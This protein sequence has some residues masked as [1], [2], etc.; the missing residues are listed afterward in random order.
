MTSSYDPIETALLARLLVGGRKPP[1]ELEVIKSLRPIVGTAE[2]RVRAALTRLEAD[3]LRTSEMKL[4]T[5]GRERARE[6]LGTTKLPTRWPGMKALLV[7]LAL[8]KTQKRNSRRLTPANVRAAALARKLDLPVA[9]SPA[10]VL[11]A[12]AARVLGMTGQRL[13]IVNVRAHVLSQ[14]L[15]ISSLRNPSHIGALAS[16]KLLGVARSDADSVRDAVLRDW[17]SAP[18]TETTAAAEEDELDRFASTVKEIARDM[19]DDGRFGRFKVFIAP[20]W[21]RARSAPLFAR[22]S[23][24][25]FKGK[26]VAAHRAGLLRLTRADLTP[27][28]RREL[29]A[30]SEVPYLNAAFHFVD[31]E[32]TLS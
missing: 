7:E 10:D 21:T 6:L 3:G 23:E 1:S 30:A 12:W 8:G 18:Q 4:T 17:L 29:V 19:S 25:D 5:K 28:M 26:L 20:I 16:A 32:G 15:G 14:A 27:A 24:A 13:T 22:M 2:A 31:L 9:S 11:D